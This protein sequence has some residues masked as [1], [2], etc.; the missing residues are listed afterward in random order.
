MTITFAYLWEAGMKHIDQA[1]QELIDYKQKESNAAYN[2]NNLQKYIQLKEEIWE[3][4]PGSKVEYV[5]SYNIAAGLLRLV[6]M[7]NDIVKVEKWMNVLYFCFPTRLDTGNREAWGGR[8]YYTLGDFHKA[9]ELL[10]VAKNK[11]GGRCFDD[12]DDLKYLKLLKLGPEEFIKQLQASDVSS[13]HGIKADEKE[14]TVPP[15]N[16]LSMAHLSAR[17][18]LDDALSLKLNNLSEMG[19]LLM[20]NGSYDNA[21]NSFSDALALL[22]LPTQQWEAGTWLYTAIGEAYYFK[23]DYENAKNNLYDALNCADSTDSAFTYLRLEQSLYEL[24]DL[25]CAKENLL[26]AYMLEGNEI[27]DDEEE[28]YFNLLLDII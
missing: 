18:D 2:N 4:L 10:V 9:Y 5:E 8:T 20:D 13:A 19:N 15:E 7:V 26:K 11:S 16:T 17:Y 28:K 1:I 24:G 21:I 12:A 25:A 6:I 14:V 23:H 22:P 3:L 27:F